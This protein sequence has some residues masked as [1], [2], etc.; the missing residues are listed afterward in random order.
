MNNFGAHVAKEPVHIIRS[1][2]HH[3]LDS[4]VYVLLVNPASLMNA[5][6]LMGLINT[7]LFF[8]LW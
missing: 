5:T 1:I 7:S 4:N 3:F 2:E 6:Q 8:F